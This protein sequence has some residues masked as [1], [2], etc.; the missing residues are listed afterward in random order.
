MS[1]RRRIAL[2]SAAAVAIAVVLASI[3]TYALTSHQLHSQVDEQLHNRGRTAGRLERFLKPGS[4]VAQR[5]S[6]RLGRDLNG[7]DGRDDAEAAATQE[8]SQAQALPR[9]GPTAKNLFGRLQPGPDQVRGYQQVINSAGTI[10]VRSARE[11]SL[12]VDAATLR[13]A[14]HGGAPFFVDARVNGIHL[15]VLAEPFGR[16]RAVQLAQP[17]TE[18]DSLLSRLRLILALLDLAGIAIAALLGRLVAGAAVLPLKRLTQAAEHVALTQDLSGRIKSVGQDE[19]GRLARSFNAMLDALER[20]I[21]ALDASVHAQR[22]LVADASHELRT[23]V[24]SLR[25][26]IEILQQAESMDLADRRRLLSDVVEQIEELTLLIN[27]LI[28]LARGEEPFA[29]AEDVRLDVLV[30][31]VVERAQRHAPASFDVELEPTI[32][33]GVPARLERAITNLID[34]AVK[35]SPPGEPVEIAL[36]GEQLTVRDHGP[37]ISDADLPHVFDRFYRGAEARGRPGSGLGLAI[38]RQVAE[39]QGG[40]VDAERAPGG[41]TLMRLCLARAESIEPDAAESRAQ[42]VTP[43]APAPPGAAGSPAASPAELAGAE[44]SRA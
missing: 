25:T 9:Y 12:P 43:R 35:Y 40:R 8:Q 6:E 15:R 29:P 31:E 26:N 21:G 22:Q 18:V 28:E 5:D 4:K 7:L 30:A 42:S 36:S 38:V 32:V 41:G 13:L 27:D 44:R 11:V 39:Q 3:L 1:F 14:K 2:A 17:L 19:I 20:S 24:T 23:P 16:G 10:V 34:N 33:P 37:G